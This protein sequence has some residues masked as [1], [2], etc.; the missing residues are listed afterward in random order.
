M[1]RAAKGSSHFV[2]KHI[3]KCS[4]RH[5]KWEANGHKLISS[6]LH[7]DLLG[8]YY[9]HVVFMLAD[10]ENSETLQQRDASGSCL[11]DIQ[12]SVE[13]NAV[14][15][16]GCQRLQLCPVHHHTPGTKLLLSSYCNLLV[17]QC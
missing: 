6:L 9:V 16:F 14:D 2:V 11:V 7:L 10:Y 13:R 5:N 4:C 12:R 1:I 15:A 17:A 3:K 8:I